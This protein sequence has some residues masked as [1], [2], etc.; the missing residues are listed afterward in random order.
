MYL[1]NVSYLGQSMRIT[2]SPIFFGLSALGVCGS[3]LA[4]LPASAAAT[5]TA[6]TVAPYLSSIVINVAGEFVPLTTK[7]RE[8]V[9]VVI[10]VESFGVPYVIDEPLNSDSYTFTDNGSFV[11]RFHNALGAIGS[12]TITIDNIDR[13]PPVITIDPYTTT[14]TNA[15]IEVTAST[16]EGTLN[17]SSHLFTENGSFDFVATDEAGNVST[18]TVTISTIDKEAPVLT[19]LGLASVE[20]KLNATYTDPGATATDNVDTTV[21][22]T[23]ESTLNE[24]IEGTY[25]ITYHATDSAGNNAVPITRTVMVTPKSSG[26]GGGG[27]GTVRVGSVSAPTEGRVLGASTYN[28]TRDL[29]VKDTGEDVQ[30]LQQLLVSLGFLKETPTGYFGVKTRAAVSAYQAAHAIPM[31]GVLGPRTRAA[32]SGSMTASTTT[33]TT[34]TLQAQ[35]ALLVAQVQLLQAKLAALSR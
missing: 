27:G 20:S 30:A 31:T 22:V 8:N 24:A 35:I 33:P 29:A 4:P 16:N 1:R 9:R 34:S 11:F 13:T 18:S 32:L 2:A 26:R 23:T 12:S 19:L 21:V 5:F 25:T 14:A 3:L 28:F 10:T 7:T 6:D 15:D 17:A